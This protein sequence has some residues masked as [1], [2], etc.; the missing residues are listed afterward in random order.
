MCRLMALFRLGSLA[1]ICLAL[2]ASHAGSDPAPAQPPGPFPRTV[3]DSAGRRV[4]IPQRPLIIAAL[5]DAPELRTVVEPLALR[6]AD[7]LSDPARLDWSGVGLLVLSDLYAAIAPAWLEAAAARGVPVFEV[8][9]INS[10]DEWRAVVEALGC[11]TG[12][13]DRAAAALRRLES[14]LARLAERVAL[15]APKRVLVLTP[16]GYTFGQGTLITDL[17]AAIGG[18]NVAAE[19]GFEDYRQIDDAAIDQ[20]A[21]EV[22]LLSSAWGIEQIEELRANPALSAVPAIRRNRVYRLPFSPTL[23][24]EPAAAAF[25]LALALYPPP[26]QL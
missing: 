18:V 5:G 23:P 13:D 4:L 16:E 25:V 7:P 15:Q 19:A 11:A 14:R 10:L 21:P 3:T 6:R 17:L 1:A 8:S 20:L 2:T 24:E 9:A 22:L 26:L 12:R